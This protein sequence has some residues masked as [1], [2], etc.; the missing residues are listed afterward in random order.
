[1]SKDNVD[2]NVPDA[3][4]KCF[5]EMLKGMPE[6]SQVTVEY[7]PILIDSDKGSRPSP[8]EDIPELATALRVRALAEMAALF[9][10]AADYIQRCADVANVKGGEEFVVPSLPRNSRFR[11][12]LTN[13]DGDADVSVVMYPELTEGAI[14]V[15]ADEKGCFWMVRLDKDD[16]PIIETLSTLGEYREV[17]DQ[18][19]SAMKDSPRLAEEASNIH[20]LFTALSEGEATIDLQTLITINVMWSAV[21]MQ[22][23]TQNESGTRLIYVNTHGQIGLVNADATNCYLVDQPVILILSDKR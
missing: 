2:Q 13:A 8:I 17:R 10:S 21:I 1:M 5:A 3:A 11:I 12:D 7:L 19:A 22:L 4:A 6:L 14:R 16:R 15:F 20:Q 18:M 9:S 23:F